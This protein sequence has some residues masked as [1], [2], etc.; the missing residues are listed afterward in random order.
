MR[1]CTLNI[2]HFQPGHPSVTVVRP[3]EFVLHVRD[4]LARPDIAGEKGEEGG[5]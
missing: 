4:W 5:E 2:G 3:G 1:N